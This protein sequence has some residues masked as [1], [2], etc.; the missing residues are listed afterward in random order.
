[1]AQTVAR[2]LREW[3]KIPDPAQRPFFRVTRSYRAYVQDGA[4]LKRANLIWLIVILCV[5]FGVRVLTLDAQ[6]LWNDE[7]NSVALAQRSFAAI[8]AAAAQDIHPP[9]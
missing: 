7:G 2:A 4:W 6:S 1:M 5:A 9:L 3:E 8:A